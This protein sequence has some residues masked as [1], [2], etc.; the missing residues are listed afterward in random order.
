MNSLQLWPPLYLVGPSLAVA[1]LVAV[2]TDYPAVLATAALT[3]P[4]HPLTRLF[5]SVANLR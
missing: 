4:I 2:V 3:S 1:L 5:A